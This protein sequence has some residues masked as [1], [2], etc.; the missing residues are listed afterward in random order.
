MTDAEADKT[1][2]SRVLAGDV[3]AFSS[4]LTRHRNHVLGIV[5]RHVPPDQV[6]ETAQDVFVRAFQSLA[7]F[8]QA[9]RFRSWLSAIAVRTCYDYWR[10]RYRRNEVPLSQLSEAHCA[11]LQQAEARSAENAWQN[12]ASRAEAREVLDWALTQLSAEDRMVIELV[13]LEERSVQEAAKLLGWSVANVKV[14]A[15]RARK[16]MYKLIQGKMP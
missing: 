9:D 13:H 4:L 14:R 12:L 8:R 6:Q 10:R 2:V 3:N 1:D 15:F 7:S 16:K 5:G 11:W